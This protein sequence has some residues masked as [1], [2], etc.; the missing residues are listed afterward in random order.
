MKQTPALWP[1]SEE[2]GY[3]HETGPYTSFGVQGYIKGLPD[4]SCR[5]LFPW[6]S[7]VA[8]TITVGHDINAE[9]LARLDALKRR[10][11]SPEFAQAI[12]DAIFGETQ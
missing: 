4:Y 9:N 8:I 10:M 5:P 3:D 12:E 6:M 1:N 2:S 11:R 7:H